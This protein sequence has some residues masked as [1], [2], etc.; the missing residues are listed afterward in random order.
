MPHAVLKRL[1]WESPVDR[2]FKLIHDVLKPLLHRNQCKLLVVPMGRQ[3]VICAS[4]RDQMD[5]NLVT[6]MRLLL[7]KRYRRDV[8]RHQ[9]QACASYQH[10]DESRYKKNHRNTEYKHN[11][12]R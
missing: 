6:E 7:H 9:H 2:E 10:A 4:H 11:K 3:K 12:R 1:E 8:A 5:E